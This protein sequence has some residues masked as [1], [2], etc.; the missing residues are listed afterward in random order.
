MSAARDDWLAAG[1]SAA[2]P[3]TATIFSPRALPAV[4]AANDTRE[5]EVGVKFSPD[6]NMYATAIRFYK[7]AGNT[8]VHTGT[9]WNSKGVAIRRIIFTSETASGWQ[10][11]TFAFPAALRAHDVYTVSYHALHGRY[12]FTYH[13]FTK[14]IDNGTFRMPA[15]TPASGNGVYKYGASGRPTLASPAATNYWV[16]VAMS[17]TLPPTT[18]TTPTTPTTK[19]PA[20]TT[21]TRSTTPTTIALTPSAWPNATNTGVKPGTVLTPYTGSLTIESCG[22]VIDSKAIIG[23]LSIDAGNGTHSSLT[24]CVTIKNSLIIGSVYTGYAS[25]NK[26]PTVLTDDEIAYPLSKQGAT[27]ALQEANFYGWRLD[28]HGAVAG[29]ACDGYCGLHDSFLHGNYYVS[30][31]H[32]DAFISNGNAGHPIVLDHNS[33]LCT[34]VNPSESDHLGGCSA[35]I[36]LFGDFS[37]ISNVTA[38]NNLLMASMDPAYC[39]YTGAEESSK[40]FP[41]GT[42]LV[43]RNNVWQ[44]GTNSKC[45][46]YGAVADWRSGNGNIWCNNRW[47]DGTPVIPGEPCTG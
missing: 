8:G 25:Q 32:L 42:N 20:T 41:T 3:T 6:I 10:R 45:A 34:V 44:R 29:V 27:N 7:G 17:T 13:Y 31:A 36:G 22:V 30:P 21:T 11:A 37:A 2:G 28:I 38:T 9:L 18:T 16:D 15:S 5:V 14:P 12:A 39:V 1:T 23:D 24:P 4:A 35:D 26:G 46:T 33:F 43:W 47:S 19:A 40:A